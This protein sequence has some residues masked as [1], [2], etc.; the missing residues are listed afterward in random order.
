MMM[1]N[2]T[3]FRSIQLREEISLNA[4]A[5]EL[6]R[7]SSFILIHPK[8][9]RYTCDVSR[10]TNVSRIYGGYGSRCWAS[11]WIN[12]QPGSA[13]FNHPSGSLAK[14]LANWSSNWAWLWMSH[15]KHVEGY[16]TS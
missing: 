8:V 5:L 1:S 15:V 11:I 10:L 16:G 6:L 7:D 9:V 12:L 13:S 2:E 14:S 3:H 4:S